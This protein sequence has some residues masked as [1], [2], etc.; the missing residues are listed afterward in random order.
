M[1]SALTSSNRVNIP[2]VCRIRF[3]ETNATAGTG[4]LVSPGI[5]L[6]STQVIENATKAT[7]L[8]ATFFENTKKKSVDAHFLPEKY[9]F[10]A[11]FPDYMDYCLVACDENPIVNVIPVRIPLIQKE[12]TSVVESETVLIVQHRIT[13]PG[14]DEGNSKDDNAEIK[15][16]DE[17]L[18]CREDLFF[19]KVN[20]ICRNAGCPVFNDNGQ[21]IGIQ[22]Q[23]RNGDESVVNRALSITAIVKHL[24]ANS[25]LCKL[26]QR[27]SFD[28]VW[29]TWFVTSDVSRIL[30]IMANFNHLDM[31]R[32]AVKKLCE[33]T[34]V[35]S[36][37][38]NISECGGVSAMV[39]CMDLFLQD[40]EIS[41][42]TLRGLWNV[43]IG[44]NETLLHIVQNNG[45][46][47]IISIMER[48]SEV[49]EIQQFG[50]V[51]TFNLA[52]AT[53]SILN[54][55]LAERC[56]AAVYTAL[57]KFQGSLVIQKFSVNFCSLA[58]QADRVFSLDLVKQGIFQH[59]ASLIA[60]HPDHVFLME[61]V[62]QLASELSQ[63]REVVELLLDLT[64]QKT[65][66]SEKCIVSKLIDL[67]INLMI[68][69]ADNRKV[70]LYGNNFLWGVGSNTFC[71]W[72][73][74]KHPKCYE[75]LQLSSESLR[76]AS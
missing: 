12:W 21:L 40:E 11:E 23:F 59:L 26:P 9:F 39:S 50:T 10:A 30:L 44:N 55:V 47:K 37:V 7:S 49:E 28:D 65:E 60:C 25:Q 74:L 8:C 72:E 24:F 32:A 3:R 27:I 22:S 69:L 29:N 41:L 15:R 5:I 34:T 62:M 76:S 71:R 58:I 2:A 1:S 36:L 68:S 53:S 42:L 17:I 51:L 35:P 75:V 38:K 6:T 57:L 56:L 4:V 18:R 16:F 73:L 52:K 43:S 70:Q 66:S 14:K 13:E 63:N 48:F 61:V 64:S 19:F 31:I 54:G 20:G 67:V 46:E 45:L 33:L